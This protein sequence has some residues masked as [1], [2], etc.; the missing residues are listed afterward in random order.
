MLTKEKLKVMEEELEDLNLIISHFC[1]DIDELH[2]KSV[3][4]MGKDPRVPS[5]NEIHL[6]NNIHYDPSR[7]GQQE[8][9]QHTRLVVK[10]LLLRKLSL[11]GNLIQK[12]IDSRRALLR[13]I[14]SLN[15]G[16]I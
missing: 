7:R 14:T 13:N 10:D 12:K 3:V 4:S 16:I 5:G 8:L 1:T 2:S 9:V 6:I 15:Y 11:N